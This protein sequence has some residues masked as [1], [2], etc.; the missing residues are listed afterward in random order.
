MDF[1]GFGKVERDR[2]QHKQKRYT[3]GLSW[4]FGC[5]PPLMAGMLGC[6]CACVRAPLVPRHS[7][8]GCAV[9]ACVLGLRFWLGPATPGWSVGV[10]VIVC[11]FNL[12]P[13]T[14][15]WVVRCR[16]CAWGRVSAA[17]R[18]S[19][20]GCWDVSALACAL[21]LYLATPGWGV[22][23]GC[24]CLDSG[25]ACAP[26]LLAGVSGCVC[27]FVRASIVP[28]HSWLGFVV[29]GFGVAWHLFRSRG[30]MRVVLA[31]RV[32]STRWPLLLG[33]CSCA[34]VVAGSVPLWRACCPRVVR[35]ASSGPVAL[36]V[37]VGFPDAVVPFPTPGACGGLRY[38]SRAAPCCQMKHDK[39][40]S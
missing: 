2:V 13:A 3:A 36:G 24:V 35:R 9:W 18:H 28:R 8:L 33:T 27:A 29:C 22:R 21:H 37:L 15:G 38:L 6:V 23:C 34:L 30:S 25:F 20:L 40:I 4:G 14:P 19:W 17:P 12:Y 26:P 39:N 7:W 11:V 1:V 32:C 16:V 31:A 5:A 10:C